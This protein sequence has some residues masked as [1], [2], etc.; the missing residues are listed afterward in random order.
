VAGLHR[1]EAARKCGHQTIRAEVYDDLGDDEAKLLRIDENLCRAG[2]DRCRG[3]QHA[4][5]AN[6]IPPLPGYD[7]HGVSAINP[8]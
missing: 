4:S 8:A 5:V 2:S 7:A 3:R 1:L 6:G